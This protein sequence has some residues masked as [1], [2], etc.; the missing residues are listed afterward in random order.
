M[1]IHMK[2]SLLTAAV[3]FLILGG[4]SKSK[5]E[6]P[7]S[8]TRL[9]PSTDIEGVLKSLQLTSDFFDEDPPLP[10]DTSDNRNWY[11][12]GIQDTSSVYEGAPVT[13]KFAV[14]GVPPSYQVR[15]LYLEMP[16]A[17]GHWLIKQAGT[18]SITFTIPSLV[19]P[20]NLN[21]V[22][23]AKLVKYS[24]GVAQDSF[25]TAKIKQLVRFLEPEGCSFELQGKNKQGLIY[26]KINLGDKA[27]TLKVKFLSMDSSTSNKTSDRFDLKYN[28]AYILSSSNTKVPAAYIPACTGLAAGAQRKQ[29]WREYSYEYDPVNGTKAELFIQSNC[30]DTTKGVS[31][32][33]KMEC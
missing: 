16:P 12:V 32:E 26:R 30:S 6:I 8:S 27:G 7:D 18:A 25:Y 11:L 9:D 19:R 23:S 3:V 5:I 15:Q 17:T 33:F 21:M 24:G 4:C 31:W 14:K 2:F 13:L 10:S 29:G 22:V 28:A 20:G 1:K